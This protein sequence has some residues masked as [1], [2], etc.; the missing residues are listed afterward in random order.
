MFQIV[1]RN[2]KFFLVC[3]GRDITC[4]DTSDLVGD[5]SY[6][7]IDHILGDLD[8]CGDIKLNKNNSLNTNKTYCSYLIFS[9]QKL[10]VEN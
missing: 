8:R 5:F 2:N 10:L 3:D 6:A 1:E 7:L 4:S 9:L